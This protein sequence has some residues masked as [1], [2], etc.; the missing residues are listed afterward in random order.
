MYDNFTRGGQ[1][2]LHKIRMFFQ[3]FVRT[4][5]IAAFISFVFFGLKS[6]TD[7]KP[8]EYYL[9][10]SHIWADLKLSFGDSHKTK[11]NFWNGKGQT[12]EVFSISILRNKAF[13]ENTHKINQTLIKNLYL[14]I[15]AWVCIFLFTAIFWIW[16]GKILSK[17]KHLSGGK[18]VSDGQLSKLI[19]R[20][21]SSKMKIATIPVP[22]SALKTHFLVTGTTGSGKTNCLHEFLQQIRNQHQKA[23][24]IDLTGELVSCYYRPEK[25]FILNPFDERSQNWNMWSE[26][27]TPYDFD[28]LAE[29]M[30][31]DNLQD[32]FWAQSSRILLSAAAQKFKGKNPSMTKLLDVL[33]KSSHSEFSDFFKDT[34][35]FSFASRDAEKTAAS[36][37]ATVSANLHC[38]KYLENNENSFSVTNWV[39]TNKEDTWLFITSLPSQRAALRPLLSSWAN[40]VFKALMA[41]SPD[42]KRQLWCIVDEL[43]ALNKLPK[44]ATFLAEARKYGGSLVLGLQDIPQLDKIYSTH[45]TKSI[46]GLCNTK[47]IFRAGDADTAKRLS[48]LFGESEISE[49]VKNVSFG[50]NE[51]RDGISMSEHRKLQPLVT[52]T[53][54]MNLDPLEAIIKI[55]ALPVSK[56]KFKFQNRAKISL[57]FVKKT[58]SKEKE[59]DK[60]LDLEDDFS[61]ETKINLYHI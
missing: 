49:I 12:N 48:Q 3:I 11:Q 51:I 53:E 10:F 30:I 45:E 37:R 36:I 27:V 14:S 59:N 50:A 40:I 32:P 25:D 35:A 22:Q 8:Y 57:P 16:R 56:I 20:K 2:V 9:Y 54:C 33:L 60:E 24:V 4:S 1:T 26:C 23:V 52:S 42:P 7:Y 41:L 19:K 17:K 5:I 13:K 38:F 58:I 44:L 29:S 6:Y 61:E 28:D 43:P 39:Q 47:V 34:D 55:G 18:R 46:I 31:P 15:L 21:D